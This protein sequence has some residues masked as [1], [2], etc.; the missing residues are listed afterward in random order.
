MAAR[1]HAAERVLVR[2]RAVEAAVGGEDEGARRVEGRGGEDEVARGRGRQRTGERPG[3]VVVQGGRGVE[4]AELGGAMGD[5]GGAAQ[6]RN[7]QVLEE[8][9][10]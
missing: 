6:I 7:A 2:R 8:G 1:W 3:G 10:G 4:A 9:G 5:D